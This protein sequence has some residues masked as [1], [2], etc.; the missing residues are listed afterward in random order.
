MCAVDIQSNTGGNNENRIKKLTAKSVE[1]SSMSA[2]TGSIVA[3][4][5]EV[6]TPTAAST[7]VFSNFVAV[8]TSD[9]PKNWA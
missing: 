5:P 6:I 8:P 2:A 9:D 3:G 7:V 4:K 1:L